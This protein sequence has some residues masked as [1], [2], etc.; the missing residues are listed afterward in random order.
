MLRRAVSQKLTDIS[1]LVTAS[2]STVLMAQ[3]M[4]VVNTSQTL[5]SFYEKLPP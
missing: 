5:V 4:E 1:E 2:I 3:M